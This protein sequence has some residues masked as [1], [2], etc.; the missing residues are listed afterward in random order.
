[1]RLAITLLM[2]V[3]SSAALADTHQQG[4]VTRLVVEQTHAS[5]WIEGTPTNNDCLSDGRW[6]MDFASD[7]VAREKYATL[8]AAA[9]SRQVVDLHYYSAQSCGGFGAKKISYVDTSY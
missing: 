2:L 9:S 5:V 6:V 1:M 4:R 8:L 3:G 7:P